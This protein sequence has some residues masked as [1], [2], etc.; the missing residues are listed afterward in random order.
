MPHVATGEDGFPYLALTGG[1]SAVLDGG[2]A[3]LLH[4]SGAACDHDELWS[5]RH[6]TTPGGLAAVQ[7]AHEEYFAAGAVVATTATYQCSFERFAAHGFGRKAAEAC[8]RCGV[9]AACRARESGRG[10]LLVAGSLGAYGAHLADGSEYTGAYGSSVSVEEL[11]EFHVER[12]AVLK[13]ADGCDLLAFETVPV[14]A[15]A[16]ALAVAADRLQFPCWV[17]FSC[18]SK[19]QL[20]SGEPFEL[21]VRAALRSRYIVGVGVNCSRPEFCTDL[22]GLALREVAAADRPRSSVRLFCYP[23]SGEVWDGERREWLTCAL[24]SSSPDAG[25][26]DPPISDGESANSA[27]KS[28]ADFATEW[29]DLGATF[30]GGCCRVGP[31]DIRKIQVALSGGARGEER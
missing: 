28:L 9:A 2:L 22:L 19:T 13:S 25:D 1:G 8:M 27:G 11:A 10:N 17:S 4:D 31:N 16:E 23:N 14:V 30:I 7:K 18:S 12:G 21:A 6:L 5:A 29:R 3:T 20:C 24:P 26:G 15:E